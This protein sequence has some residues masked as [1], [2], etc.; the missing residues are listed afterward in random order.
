M[1][2]LV[3]GLIAAGLL[4]SAPALAAPTPP[5]SRIASPPLQ[6]TELQK[7][8]IARIDRLVKGEMKDCARA[9]VDLATLARAPGFDMIEEG[10]RRGAL[11]SIIVCGSDYTDADA[12]FA[13]ERLEPIAVTPFER[14]A[15]NLPLLLRDLNAEADL[16]AAGRMMVVLDGAP[17]LVSHWDSQWFTAMLAAARTGDRATHLGLLSRLLRV[18]WTHVSSQ[19]AARTS[20]RMDLARLQATTGNLIALRDT[21]RPVDDPQSLIMIAQDR[22]FEKLWPEM[23]AAGRFDW[24]AVAEADLA[25][26]RKRSAEQPRQLSAVTDVIDVLRLLGRAEE[27]VTLGEAARARLGAAGS[28]E[29]QDEKAAWL[30]RSLALALEDLDRRGDVDRVFAEAVAAGDK[31]SDRISQRINWA[32]LLLIH[33]RPGKV[34][35]LMDQIGDKDG[36]DYGLAL[37]ETRRVCALADSDRP[38]AEALLGKVRA[39]AQVNPSAA[40]QAYVCLGLMDEA[41]AVQIDRLKSEEF[42]QDALLSIF[43]GALYPRPFTPFEQRIIDRRQAISA[44]PEVARALEAAGRPIQTP[45]A[46]DYWSPPPAR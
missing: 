25:R 21:L 6:P 42:R 1:R 11:L 31:T 7:R 4:L 26:K 34:L 29:D 16:K 24:Q 18:E 39:R 22:R 3:P 46:G 36:S 20:W 10:P 44:R 27:A 13:A 37:R 12:L 33:D 17:E 38:K 2:I 9:R 30:L 5:D 19:E 35:E 45:Y 28:F 40:M 23:E 15:L 43:R 32:A 14:A 8:V 41:A